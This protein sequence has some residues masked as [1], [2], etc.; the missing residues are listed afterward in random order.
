MCAGKLLRLIFLVVLMEAVGSV[1][2]IFTAPAIGGWYASLHKP[3][4]TPPNWLFAPVWITLFAL[5]GV[6]LYL[7]LERRKDSGTFVPAISVFVVQMFLNVL[8]SV[9]FFGLH[10]PLLGL[11]CIVA[12]LA[13]IAANA[14]LFFRISRLSGALLLPYL[15]WVSVA[16]MLN[17]YVL[18][19]N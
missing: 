5:I 19:L 1:G 17:L 3:A 4:F 14:V 18:L 12:L 8:W 6:S 11:V 2:T 7:V 13:A 10:S 15:S 9:L 16:T